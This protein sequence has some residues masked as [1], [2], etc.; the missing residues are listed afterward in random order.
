[1]ATNSLL[2][3]PNTK[4]QTAFKEKKVPES[5]LKAEG[6]INTDDK[7]KPLP[8]QGHLIHDNV[9]NSIKYF[10]KDRAYDLKSVKNGFLGTANDHQSGRLN[11]VGLATAGILIA[12]FLAS[13]TTDPKAKI[14]EYVGL[15][16][17]LA[18]M[19]IYPKIAINAPAKLMHG[20]DIDK[21]Y[22]DDQGRK[23][24][25]MQDANYVPYD[26]YLGEVPDEDIA[27]IGDDM[28]IPRNI[29]NRNDVIREQMRKNATQSQTL[30][31]LTA[32]VT[33]ALGS[34]MSYGLEKYVVS[35]A[36]ANIRNSVNNKRISQLLE[37]T[38]K[39]ET[40]IEAL[41]ANKLTKNVQFLLSGY[42][43]QELPKVEFDNLI[44]VVTE[45]L[46]ANAAEGVKEDLANIL[47][48]SANGDAG[49][50][51][52]YKESLDDIIHAAQKTITGRNRNIVEEILVPS[53]E[54]LLKILNTHGKDFDS[55]AGSTISKETVLK[56]KEAINE[57]IESKIQKTEG[58][59][60]EFLHS[61]KQ[62]VLENITKTLQT[63]K[64]TLLTEETYN[65]IIDFTKIL[66]EFKTNKA[67]LDKSKSFKFE[68][69][70]QTVLARSYEKFE[71][72]L[73]DVLGIK[74]K[75]LKKMR[76]S[77]G[78]T[79][80]LLDQK[81]SALCKDEARYKQ[82]I[83][84]L[85]KIVSEME[86]TLNGSDEAKSHILDLISAT[87]NNY[88]N[89]AK[90]L[91]K[92]GSFE[93][94]IKRLVKEDVS[95]LENSFSNKQ[96]LFDFL[97]GIVENPFRKG[98]AEADKAEYVRKVSK[99]I[100]SSKNQE[101]SKMVERY[102]GVKNSFNRIMHTMDVYKR[103]LTPES[104][105]ETLH[106]KDKRYIE[107][108]IKKA[109]DS[110]LEATASDHTLKLDTVNN[111][112]FYKDLMNSVWAGEAENFWSTK[113]KGVLTN[114]AKE[115]LEKNNSLAKGNVLDRFQYYITRFRNLV[116]NN[117]IDFTKPNHR[118]SNG[119]KEH[120]TQAERTR[121]SFFNLIAQ[122]PIDMA[123]GAANRRFA[124]QKWVRIISG[125]TASIFG[126]A[127]LAQLGFG[128]LSN[129]QNL[130]KQVED[131][132]NK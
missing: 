86:V 111:P 102:Q 132:S 48:K 91:S 126:V 49:A 85:G 117:D 33:P 53:K 30:W 25:V 76:E 23:K 13:R 26:M 95:T 114:T 29:K 90:R 44:K 42:K 66:G 52:L 18:A 62:D 11:D 84:K 104:F 130:K 47:L 94:T 60:K 97:D 57:L 5:Y 8:P 121:M 68:Q 2:I 128:K 17:F 54:E 20:F 3:N 106:G 24:S 34:L 55:E 38:S 39:M 63:N 131:D 89:T 123:K 93:E 12:S 101:I 87:E 46:D 92:L 9:G 40:N 56:I 88:N 59:P 74:F 35:P 41:E 37:K 125:I 50:Y 61:Q 43:G 118:L 21:Q 105:A 116:G 67:L 80:N 108:I 109:K 81:I 45:H 6:A 120:Y 99:G 51:V 96:E 10:F 77:D 70:P 112:N 28:G 113:Q 72:T 83:E 119:I 58:I 19:S 107:E 65:K 1:M 122:T 22:I 16:A 127:L 73:L 124:T 14:M 129:P 103:S 31:M 79:K 64:S 78:F 82:A 4:I 7:I 27:L 98:V 32:C 75:D 36:T 115:A 71:A 100:G 15:G 69:A 110:L